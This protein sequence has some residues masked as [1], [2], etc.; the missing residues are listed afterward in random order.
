MGLDYPVEWEFESSTRKEQ[1]PSQYLISPH[2]LQSMGLNYLV[3]R[4]FKSSTGKEQVSRKLANILSHP[5]PSVT[6]DTVSQIF[7]CYPY[8]PYSPLRGKSF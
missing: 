6:P 5:H 8:Y 3:E 4:E 1:V 7:P 2:T